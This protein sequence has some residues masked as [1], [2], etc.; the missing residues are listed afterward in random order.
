MIDFVIL[1]Q[2]AFDEIDSNT[3]IPRQK[4][5]IEKVNDILRTRFIFDNFEEVRNF[6]K[7]IIYILKQMNY[8]AFQSD[9][10]VGFENELQQII[11]EKLKD[12]DGNK[13]LSED[14]L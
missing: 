5:M 14:I 4:Y 13:L 6:F 2:D 8:S 7:K 11:N 12:D 10:F 1:Q 9:E 3:S